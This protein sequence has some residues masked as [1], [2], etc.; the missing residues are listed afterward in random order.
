MIFHWHRDPAVATFPGHS[1]ATQLFFGLTAGRADALLVLSERYRQA[2]PACYTAKALVVPNMF[3]SSLLSLPCP[4]PQK[5]HVQVVFMGRLTREKGILDLLQVASAVI[6]KAPTTRFVLA[7]A[8]SPTEGGMSYIRELITQRGLEANVYLVGSI[9]GNEKVQFFS[10]GDILLFPSHRESFPVTV[11]EGM[12]SGIPVI[13][14]STGLLPDLIENG[15]TGFL[16]G[17]GDIHGL[18]SRL[19]QLIEDSGLRIRM[20]KNGRERVK[21]EFALE[22][23]AT[24]VRDIY[25]NIIEGV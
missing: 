19:L 6:V 2:L 23:V 25:M 11:L 1:R 13:T 9:T 5:G 17:I 3:D 4:K 10:E 12:A 21:Q 7:G 18:V 15:V 22:V 8:P 16:V 14:Y 20:G 24:K